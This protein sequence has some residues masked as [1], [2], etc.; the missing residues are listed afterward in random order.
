MGILGV[1]FDDS[2]HEASVFES[3]YEFVLV[4]GL[5]EFVI[6]G[7]YFGLVTYKVVAND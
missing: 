5:L 4:A 1:A 2:K 3:F 6:G 7:F